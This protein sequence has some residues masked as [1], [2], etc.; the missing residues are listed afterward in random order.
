MKNVLPLVLIV[1][2]FGL[3]CLLAFFALNP[4][5]N[6]AED[7]SALENELAFSQLA[8]GEANSKIISLQ[9]NE[10]YVTEQLRKARLDLNVLQ[11]VY[12]DLFTDASSCYYANY[13]LYQEENCLYTLGDLWE[14]YT[15]REIHVAE[16]NYCDGMAR[17]WK[18]Y[19]NYDVSL[20]K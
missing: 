13:C 14:G 2:I 15:A 8:L 16:S 20:T 12:S 10:K 11:G 7:V 9:E 4:A 17:D 18:K 6:H 1:V 3:L 5:P 19:Q